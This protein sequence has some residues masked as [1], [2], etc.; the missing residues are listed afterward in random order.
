MI[1]KKEHINEIA[2]VASI[3]LNDQ[4]H[5]AELSV[6][7]QIFD[8]EPRIGIL[9]GGP[10]GF[11]ALERLFAQIQTQQA[12]EPV[13]VF[14]F[15]ETVD[16]GSGPNYQ[17]D[18]P[19]YLLINY[20]IGNIDCWN[21]EETNL[22]I[23][24]QLNLTEWIKTHKVIKA[25]VKPTDYASRA[26]VGMYLQD[27]LKA[28]LETKPKAVTLHFVVGRATAIR[29][30]ERFK[31]KI[32]SQ[33]Y[34]LE[35]DQLLVSTGH[36]YRN[37][38]LLKNAKQQVEK[39]S[40]YFGSAYPIRKLDTI[41]AQESVGIIGLGLTFID[42]ALQ[43]TE[44]RGGEFTDEGDYV[45]SGKEPLIYA[46]SRNNVPILPRGPI[47]GGNHYQLRGQTVNYFKQLANIRKQ[48]KIDFEEEIYPVLKQEAQFAYYST[49]LNT[50]DEETIKKYIHSLQVEQR[51]HLEKLLFPQH[52][53]VGGKTNP[54]ISYLKASIQEATLGELNSPLLA[55]SAVWREAT[56]WIGNIYA[57]GGLTGD[58]QAMLDRQLW[59]A[60]C[61][62]SFGPPVEN[63]KKIAAVAEAGIIRFTTERW[64]TMEHDETTEQFLL[65]NHHHQHTVKYLV[66]ARIARSNLNHA[67]APLYASLL[68]NDLIQPHSN[69]GYQPGGPALTKTG[70]TIDTL[71]KSSTPLFFYGTPTEGV[72]LDNDSLSRKRNDTGSSWAKYIVNNLV[73][74]QKQY[75]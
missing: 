34:E 43:L 53:T 58:S 56:V 23:G 19:D 30:G 3:Y 68:E 22:A 69:E 64:T 70:Q 32:D 52:R 75:T 63:M 10:K 4:I 49:L 42:A 73:K 37:K 6:S 66:D 27:Q 62:T 61:R 59:G 48:R 46:F 7:Q 72:L 45:P 13:H 1:W 18:Q 14:W 5:H 21:R 36:C 2:K 15:N 74:T 16:F 47:Y 41:P 54:V 57:H 11:Y 51:F 25:D 35:V 71:K 60:F 8:E 12:D 31:L 39:L 33:P 55:A 29:Y 24:K 38:S 65:T 20:C 28:L 40:T 9:G 50:S 17:V 26:L 67:N 44:G